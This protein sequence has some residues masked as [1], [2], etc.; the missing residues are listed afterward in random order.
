LE[1][2][3]IAGRST[4]A[5]TALSGVAAGAYAVYRRDLRAAHARVSAGSRLA[6]TDFGPIEY[7]TMGDGPPV[8]F[9]HGAGGGFDQGLAFSEPL[10]RKGFAVVA[11]SRF[12]Y[13]RTPLPPDGSA[14]AQADAHAALLDALGIERAAVIAGSAGAPSGMQLAL[15]HPKRVSALVLIVPAAYVPRAQSAPALLTPRGTP[16]LFGTALRSDFLF[17]AATR[18]A[19][20]TLIESILAT[21]ARLVA[22]A[23]PK[24]RRRIDAVLAGILPVS[25]R[26]LGLVN[27]ARV[28]SNLSRY[29]LER[30]AAPTL[31]ISVADDLYGT[32]EAARYT[33]QHVPGARFIGYESGGHLW[34]GRQGQLIADVAAFLRTAVSPK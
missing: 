33:A 24:E 10:A 26:R 11:M 16:L 8:L 5:L 14:Q 12:G 19:R 3:R 18:L 32:Y 7:G 28:T 9:I 13:L 34:V 4:L 2:K 25:R 22:Y 17:W 21:P 30:I 31:A 15:R 23:E 20:D 1:V 6:R 27:D 29:E